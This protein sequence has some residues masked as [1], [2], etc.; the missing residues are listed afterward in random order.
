MPVLDVIHSP[1]FANAL[2]QAVNVIA[3]AWVG[4]SRRGMSSALKKVFRNSAWVSIIT[5]LLYFISWIEG[6]Y[7]IPAT[8]QLTRDIGTGVVTNVI[9]WRAY[10][11]CT[12]LLI[13]EVALA[14]AFNRNA[15]WHAR[16]LILAT[17]LTGDISNSELNLGYVW[18]LGIASTSF[19]ACLLLTIWTSKSR[20]FY[21]ADGEA[22]LRLDGNYCWVKLY[23][24][25]TWSLYPLFWLLGPRVF[26][27]YTVDVESWLFFASD[28]LTKVVFPWIIIFMELR[29]GGYAAGSYDCKRTDEG[30]MSLT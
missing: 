3:L 7:T 29:K 1:Y 12:Y 11:L 14:L 24:T 8:E 13:G 27:V 25:L 22:T 9:R 26:A 16:I 6:S 2:L 30:K 23:I 4:L 10:T 17:M 21:E 19:Y 5:F 18:A 28:I 15:T 20:Y